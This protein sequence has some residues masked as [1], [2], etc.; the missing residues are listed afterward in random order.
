LTGVNSRPPVLVVPSLFEERK[1][2]YGTLR[3]LANCLSAAGHPVMRF[4]FRGSGESGG[5]PSR[6]R[7]QNLVEDLGVAREAL[8][9]QSGAQ[10]ALLLGVRTGATLALLEAPRCR[11]AGVV[12]VAPIVKGANQVRLWKVRSKIRAELTSGGTAG[13]AATA[14]KAPSTASGRREADTVD[15]DGYAVHPA[16]FAD[17]SAIDLTED[18]SALPCPGLLIQVSPRA[19]PTPENEKLATVAG[20]RCRLECLRLEPFW[21]RLDDVDTALLMRKVMEFAGSL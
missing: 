16:F 20:N 8:L 1:S 2:A 4:D 6:R 10:N 14:G 18:L 19:E 15:F 17:V 7:W 21:D 13:S 9:G 11:A 5:E 12:A 3:E